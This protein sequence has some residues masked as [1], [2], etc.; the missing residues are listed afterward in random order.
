MT[1]APPPTSTDPT[2]ELARR[3]YER[4]ATGDLDG[5]AGDVVAIAPGTRHRIPWAGTWSGKAAFGEMMQTL[6]EHLEIT[7]YEPQRFV[8]AGEGRAVVLGREGV[9]TRRG[10]HAVE[11]AWVHELT[12]R[13]GLLVRF[14]E[15][16][17][18][19]RLAVALHR[20]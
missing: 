13:D 16:Y 20:G 7:L 4:L 15:H 6:G 18:T 19:D 2:L 1:P 3:F 11:T 12:F 5:L 17:D 8:L 10:G 14:A 9:R